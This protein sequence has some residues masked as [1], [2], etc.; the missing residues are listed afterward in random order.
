MRDQ[1]FLLVTEFGRIFMGAYVICT[2]M[3]ALNM[4]VA[5]MNDSFRRIMVC[6]LNS[7][8]NRGPIVKKVKS[9]FSDVFRL[10]LL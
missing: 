2:G 10:A 4:L 8:I 6:A 5:M 3:V 9:Q 1:E 7:C